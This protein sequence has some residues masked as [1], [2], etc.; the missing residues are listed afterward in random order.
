ML[1]P[2]GAMEL[3][4]GE[5]LLNYKCNNIEDARQLLAKAVYLYNRERPHS[6]IGNLTPEV[7]HSQYHQIESKSIKRLWKNYYN[8]KNTCVN[9]I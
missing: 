1:L 5:Y 6:S 9:P 7:V 2:K 8:T 4:K 3:L